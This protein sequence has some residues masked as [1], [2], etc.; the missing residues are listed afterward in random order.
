M[1]W[2]KLL[3]DLS[4]S[5]PRTVFFWNGMAIM[6]IAFGIYNAMNYHSIEI[7]IFDAMAC[8]ICWGV[9][10]IIRAIGVASAALLAVLIVT[11]D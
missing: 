3:P 2:K 10:S 7:E 1:Q 5:I 6:F 11:N 8:L 9:A 4:G